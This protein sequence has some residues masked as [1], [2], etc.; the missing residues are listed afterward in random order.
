MPLPVLSGSETI[1]NSHMHSLMLT[2]GAKL[3]RGIATEPYYVDV[4]DSAHQFLFAVVEIQEDVTLAD[5]MGL[6]EACPLL[7]DIFH[8]DFATDL[9][10]EARKGF[11]P[12]NPERPETEAMEYLEVYQDWHLDTST[13]TYS[14]VQ[15]LEF[16]GVGPRLTED[17]P[18]YYRKAGERIQWGISG[19]NL[20]S[21]LK[22]PVKVNL[23]I[24][25]READRAA[26]AYGDEI[27]RTRLEGVS[28]GQILHA[29]VWELS[30]DGTPAQAKKAW[31]GL[32][33]Q[34]ANIT[35]GKAELSPTDDFFDELYLP[36]CNHLFDGIGVHKPQEVSYHLRKLA[37]HEN[38]AQ[39][40]AEILGEEVKVVAADRKLTPF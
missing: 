24:S 31:E 28:L 13:Q 37:D 11:L 20:R 7:L 23:E 6:F 35:A 38:A 32:M 8:R 30:F 10:D 40:I 9:L 26:H 21:M 3:L 16:H 34:L 36:A 4:S 19:A 15:H 1:G 33:E 5:I 18:D 22:L 25:I 2:P 39:A 14:P 29:I 12:D 27:G 17:A